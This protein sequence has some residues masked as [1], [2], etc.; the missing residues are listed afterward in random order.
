LGSIASAS[1]RVPARGRDRDEGAWQRAGDARRLL[2][3]PLTGVGSG[4]GDA[5][6]EHWRVD[7]SDALGDGVVVAGFDAFVDGEL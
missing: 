1:F 2:A 7:A 5:E 4:F 3:T 6:S